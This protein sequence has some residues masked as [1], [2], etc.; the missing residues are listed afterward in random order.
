MPSAFLFILAI[1]LFGST[2]LAAQTK[3]GVAT[4]IKG[5]V[6]APTK[7]GAEKCKVCHKVQYDSW[8]KSEHAEDKRAECET[9]HG[10]GSGYITLAV[11]KDPAKAKAAGLI[12][13]PDKATCVTCH[14][15]GVKDE[16]LIKVH[17]HKVVKP[18]K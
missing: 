16:D 5:S 14:K 12:A 15:K 3:G 11:M 9:C 10:P 7:V 6:S 2:S 17:A 1:G 18:T 13:K 8:L 4:P